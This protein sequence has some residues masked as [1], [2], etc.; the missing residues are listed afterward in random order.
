MSTT[1]AFTAPS[2]FP[3]TTSISYHSPY[4]TLSLSATKKITLE[5]EKPLGLILEEVEEGEPKGVFID[6]VNEGGSAFESPLKEKMIGS[7]VTQVMGEEVDSLI[8]DFV[9][10]KIIDAPSPLSIE[11]E[12][13]ADEDEGEAGETEAE[14][15]EE[16]AAP[17]YEIGT[18]VEIKVIQ[19]G[20]EIMTISDA[21]VGDNL[22][23]TLLEN[24]V[25][26]YRGLKK[27]LGNC[28]GGGQC[29]FCAMDLQD[30]GE[31]KPWLLRSDYEDSRLK[32]KP[33]SYR[34]A[35]LNNIMGP[36]TVT[37]E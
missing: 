9:M 24:N 26:V 7:K 34:M 13:E 33:E 32:N 37:I 16:V 4:P 19:D 21:R 27:K 8:F 18:Q 2:F 35:C 12:V 14:E 36:A 29:G 10:E 15:E 1:T 30:D 3:R 22:R 5:L 25:E 6:D 11:I 23:K 17:V 20:K 31:G 28:G